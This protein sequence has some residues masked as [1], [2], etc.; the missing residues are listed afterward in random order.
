[1]ASAN[2]AT[3]GRLRCS[4][5]L[6]TST[7]AAPGSGQPGFH[8]RASNES[9]SKD[10]N[11]HRKIEPPRK[12]SLREWSQLIV[13]VGG[14]LGCFVAFHEHDPRAESIL[15]IVNWLAGQAPITEF[16]KVL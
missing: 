2:G 7:S 10:F 4:T 5:F 1:M 3:Q 12:I 8:K 16:R 11:A 13:I 14:F 15:K 9:N 6:T